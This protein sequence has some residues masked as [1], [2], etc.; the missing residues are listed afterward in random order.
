MKT[1]PL[2]ESPCCS[3]GAPLLEPEAAAQLAARLKALADPTRVRIVNWLASADELCVCTLVDELDLAQPTVSHHLRILREAGFVDV[4]R[5]GTWAFYRLR[6]DA[7][8]E[9]ARALGTP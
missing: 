1:L 6:P 8:A 4:D 2:L 3:P 7:V 9:L 5:R